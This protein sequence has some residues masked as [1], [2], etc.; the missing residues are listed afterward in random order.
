MRAVAVALAALIACSPRGPT[1]RDLGAAHGS[2]SVTDSGS[3]SGSGPAAVVRVPDTTLQ[4]VIAITADP[5]AT[6]ATLRLWQ[7]PSAGCSR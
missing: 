7:R 1:S 2:G 4:L 6:T 3:G 5:A